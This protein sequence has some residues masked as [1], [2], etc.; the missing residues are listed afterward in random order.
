MSGVKR[1]LCRY[2]RVKV[3]SMNVAIIGG[4]SFECCW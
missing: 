1:V 2:T 4:K 3:T